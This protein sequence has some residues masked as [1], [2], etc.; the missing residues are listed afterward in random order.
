[1]DSIPKYSKNLPN[2]VELLQRSNA[3]S[4]AFYPL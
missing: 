4:A 3:V 1:M 2:L